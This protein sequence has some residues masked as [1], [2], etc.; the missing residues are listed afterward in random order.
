MLRKW[1]LVKYLVIQLTKY[2]DV[3]RYA[4]IR[5]GITSSLAKYIGLKRLCKKFV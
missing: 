1:M 4:N 5:L 2:V 3:H